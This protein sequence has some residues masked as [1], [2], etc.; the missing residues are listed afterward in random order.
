MLWEGA[1]DR[2]MLCYYVEATLLNSFVVKPYTSF[3]HPVVPPYTSFW[4]HHNRCDVVR[5]PLFPWGGGGGSPVAPP[6]S[7]TSAHLALKTGTHSQ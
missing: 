6:T 4:R 2:D 5:A 3:W 1:F 7:P